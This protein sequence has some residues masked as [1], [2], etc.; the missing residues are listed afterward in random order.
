MPGSFSE[1]RGSFMSGKRR[2]N[3]GRV[4]HS[5][6][7]QRADGMYMFR[8][9]DLNGERK[10]IYSWKLVKTDKLPEG[11]KDSPA[12]RE[13]EKLIQRDLDDKIRTG[14]AEKTTVDD[15]F[16]RFFEMRADLKESTKC[17]YSGLYR[18]HAQPCIGYRSI[19]TV[20]RTEIQS[21]Y[22]RMVT[23]AKVK[24]STVEKLHVLLYGMFE[25]AVMDDLLRYN[26]ARSAMKRVRRICCGDESKRHALTKEEQANLMRYVRQSPMFSKWEIL[27]TVLFGTGMRIGEAL[28]LRWCDCD[29]EKG[30]IYVNHGIL[31]KPTMDGG[32]KY[33]ISSPK[34]AAGH[35]VIPMFSEVKAVLQ[36]QK[37][38]EKRHI[39]QPFFID[40]YTDFIFLNS[41]GKVYT[42]NYIYDV[43][44]RVTYSYNQEE[45]VAA[46]REGREPK[47]LPKI[48]AHIFRHTFC[49]RLCE[50]EQNIKVVQEVMGHRK[51][52]TTMDIYNEITRDKRTEVF[53]NLEGKLNL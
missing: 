44:Q 36:K 9:S 31:Y 1:E 53:K 29:F 52:T 23:E 40:G 32:Y 38:N 3:K 20:K 47:F 46:E 6:E 28:G 37:E 30:V 51:F 33:R 13:A 27:F 50:V 4:L 24:L 15:L 8:Y 42:Q 5:G 12:L 25:L 34:T 7:S 41:E 16:A 11:K 39:R 18:K 17:T 22:I 35:R 14:D 10:T 49:T 19:R 45:L 48:S 43:I 26:P 21:L 2:D